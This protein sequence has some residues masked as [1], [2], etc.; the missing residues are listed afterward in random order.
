M[1]EVR[2]RARPKQAPEIAVRKRLRPAAAPA[3]RT[4][5]R[6]PV[7][8]TERNVEVAHL[9]AEGREQFNRV[10]PGTVISCGL[11]KGN[12]AT[13]PVM[14]RL[15]YR[16]MDQPCKVFVYDGEGNVNDPKSFS[17]DVTK[18]FEEG[19]ALLA[20][21]HKCGAVKKPEIKKPKKAPA[22]ATGTDLSKIRKRAR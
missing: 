6:P 15:L 7:A 10:L 18:N 14:G 13:G 5:Q 3:V 1:I 20:K 9:I 17:M 22:W 11:C 12:N 21:K 8:R 16:R 4:R 19:M 2:T